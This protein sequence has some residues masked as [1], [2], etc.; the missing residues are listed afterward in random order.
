[1]S[2]KVIILVSGWA[3]IF[4]ATALA[5]THY[6][7]L[8]SP[9]PAPPYANWATA[10]PDIQAAVDVA[11]AGDDILVTNGVYQSGAR[12]VYGM[13]NRVAVTKA[14][15]V[16]SVNGADVTEIM[17][18]QVPG[19]TNGPASVRCVY[20]TN[21]A[22][23]EGFTLTNG[24]TQDAF[25]YYT[26]SGGGVWCESS[27]ATVSNC[28]VAGNSAHT[29]GGAFGGTLNN[30]TVTDNL[31]Y[32]NGGGSAGGALN[33]C[34]L[35]G[36]WAQQAGGGAYNG[37]LT[38]CT[39]TG[40]SAAGDGGGASRGTLNNCTLSGNRA[41][42]AGGGA[43]SCT[44]NNCSL[45]ANSA[46]GGGG[47]DDS[48]LNNC[49]LSGNSAVFGGG[50]V[51]CLLNNCIV[52]FNTA[53]QAEIA[54]YDSSSTLNYCCTTPRPAGGTGNI[55]ADPQL[56]NA[57]HLSSASPC[58]E[59]G[60]AA[61][62][63]GTD[64]DGEAWGSPPSIGCDEYHP[65]AVT[66]P[67]SVGIATAF[68]NVTVGYPLQLTGLI[69]GRTGSSEWDFGDG[70]VVTNRPYAIHAWTALGDYVV[71]LRAYNESQSGG[72]SATV[73]VHVVT[74]PVHY[75]D[76]QS[77]N[78]L[79]PYTSWATAA[80]TIQAA[81][82]AATTAGALVLV[83]NGTYASGGRTV[84]GIMTNRVAV[85][86]LVTVQSVN[87]PQ[88]TVIQGRQVPGVTNGDGAI[89]CVYLANGASL[90]GFTLTNGATRSAG[91]AAHQ[92]SGGG[93]WCES[94]NA[95]VSNCVVT[96]N[97][98][99]FDGGGASGGTLDNCT[100]SGNLADS[101][102]GASGATLNNCTLTGNS[103][104]YGGGAWY[105]TLEN[106]TIRGNT[107]GSY[108]G[109]VLLST[110][111]T[112][113]LNGNSSGSYGGGAGASTLTNCT[114]WGNSTEG[115][116]GGVVA[117]LLENCVLV[118]NSAGQ[119][120]GGAA[121]WADIERPALVVLN[122]C[123]LSNNVARDGGGGAYFSKLTHCVLSAN[124]AEGNNGGG[125]VLAGI[126]D[127][128]IV[129]SNSAGSGGGVKGF[130]LSHLLGG[131]LSG[132]TVVG[133]WAA[134]SGGGTCGC[135]IT[136]SILYFN[137]A[138]GQAPN[139]DPS[140]GLSHCCTIPQPTSGLGNITS[141]PRFVDLVGGNLRLQSNSPCINA[142]KNI[143]A[144]SSTDLDGNP[145]IAGGTVDIGAYE[146]QQPTSVIS[147]AWLEQ[148]GLP[149][150][151][152]EDLTDPDGDGMDNWQEWI[153][154][155]NPTNAASALRLLS[156]LLTSTNVTITWQSIEGVNYFLKRSSDL[157]A[158]QPAFSTVA[159]D[160]PGQA[161]T[162]SYTD[163]NA[164]GAG[165]FFYRIGVAK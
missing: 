32:V 124:R 66:G 88:F 56:A 31:A 121:G 17:G 84:Y 87:G 117:G 89:R 156:P 113:S 136:N 160:I 159:T 141:D 81:V 42:E 53:R 151:G 135:A 122:N 145:R 57:S 70:V 161:G 59:A 1:M 123:I 62:T 91:D 164:S 36:N 51:S 148:Y 22:L 152:S 163:T 46:I 5:A 142:G 27:N 75:V 13:S 73:V 55:S 41:A 12:A 115:D 96:G 106:C 100:L 98:A 107:A 43:S 155:T 14:V 49:T 130:P 45:S 26:G 30:C 78:P 85:T 8:N 74:Q 158:S 134:D 149:T 120:G 67:L 11:A 21:G 79:A 139:Y 16:R 92:Q 95:V 68:T 47:T 72:I 63:I 116:G 150:D 64:I 76:A 29:G 39:L 48:T 103:A 119:G 24:A 28:L 33:N 50:A 52:Y 140:S 4:A 157:G 65:D 146:F 40:N 118:G 38:N 19:M 105:G 154:G 61:F 82:D 153:A 80:T 93:V 86:K 132:C 9:G 60:N 35:S 111:N 15:M 69:E 126:L 10:A 20:L 58:R 6:V 165:T 102:G 37:M 104:N 131:G 23:L 128:C 94:P 133:N 127:D 108:G 77:A 7:D 143:Y 114:V 109:G 54:N 90:S 110:L 3:L 138:S 71:V 83:T 44:L 147:Y 34:T 112:C 129:S 101:G 99:Y 144:P 25:D 137:T 18:Y 125:G 97:Y 2:T 162:T